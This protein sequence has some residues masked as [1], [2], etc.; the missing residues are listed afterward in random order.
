MLEV[1]VKSIMSHSSRRK[2]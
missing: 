2:K 1:F